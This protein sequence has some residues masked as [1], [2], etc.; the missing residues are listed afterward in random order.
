MLSSLDPS[1]GAL[2]RLRG[3]PLPE[4]GVIAIFA[5]AAELGEGEVK[6]LDDAIAATEDM[7][8]KTEAEL[9]RLSN[10][11]AVPA[12]ADLLRARGAR[13]EQ[14][15]GLRAVMERDRT[16][17]ELRLNEVVRF[18]REI[19]SI[20]RFLL[21]DTERA[22]RHEDAQQRLVASRDQRERDAATLQRIQARLAELESRWTQ[23]WA[24]SGL[25]PRS[26]AEMARWR[27]RVDDVLERL[28]K[29]D[30]QKAAIDALGC[31][32]RIRAKSRSSPSSK[33]PAAIR[34]S[35][36]P[37]KSCFARPRR[38][39]TNCMPHGPT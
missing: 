21:S 1:P 39:S 4:N 16:E 36:F 23:L 6:R 14:I 15:E 37:P 9:A 34:T 35:G 27:A 30:P 20:T 26:P 12:R 25:T 3:L 38:G 22:T 2:D 7:I 28:R 29:R 31:G 24:A 19:D 5:N 10:A 17:R 13:D 18:S 8:A 11:G 33:A 32:S